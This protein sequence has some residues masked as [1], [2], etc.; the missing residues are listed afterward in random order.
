MSKNYKRGFTLIELLVVI[1]IIGILSSIVLA[2]L[3]TA[4]Q[5]GTIAAIKGNMAGIRTSAE[6]FYDNNTSYGTDF[7]LGDCAA[8]ASTLF[9]DTNIN[10]AI[11]AVEGAYA[12]ADAQCVS[13]DLTAAAGGTAASSWAVSATLP[14]T[15]SWCVNSAG[16]AKAGAAIGGGAAAASCS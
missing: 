3:N 5:K 13:S 8:T 15:T 7:D 9:A 4:R 16:V 12:N 1:A 2:S 14:D 11:V 10:Q 6:I